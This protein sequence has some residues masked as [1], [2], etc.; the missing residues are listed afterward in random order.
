MGEYL[1]VYDYGT[2]TGGVWAVTHAPSKA[3]IETACPELKVFDER[4]AWMSEADYE[5]TETTAS[6]LVAPARLPHPPSA[7]EVSA[8]RYPP[9]HDRARASLWEAKQHVR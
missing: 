8:S 2:G 7:T 6:A 1:I 4:P 3:A 5:T 9:S